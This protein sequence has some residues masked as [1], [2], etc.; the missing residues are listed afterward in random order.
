MR[1]TTTAPITAWDTEVVTEFATTA[2]DDI[3]VLA[4]DPRVSLGPAVEAARVHEYLVP[5]DR[6]NVAF[7]VRAGLGELR[8]NSFE[9]A[10]DLIDL[11]NS[12]LDQFGL[13][14]ARLRV[15]VTRSQSCPKFHCDNVHVRLVTT[16]VGPTTEYQYAGESATHVAPLFGLV[17][18]KGHRHP[19]HQD[20]V[21]HRSPE[22]PLGEKRLC[23]AIDF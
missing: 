12:F 13:Q 11:V 1:P 7:E 21:H 18:L 22:V 19:N 3:L 10:N 2:N 8:I 17:F 5:V 4:R 16:Y 23:V 9:L 20:R 14:Q 15:E 6:D